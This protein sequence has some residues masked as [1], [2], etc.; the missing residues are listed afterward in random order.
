[1]IPDRA[2]FDKLMNNS[3]SLVT[4]SISNLTKEVFERH[5][6]HAPPLE[7]IEVEIIDIF[8]VYL[9]KDKDDHAG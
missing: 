9:K 8:Q 2:R 3:N 4:Q 7:D 5:K 6:E 1:M